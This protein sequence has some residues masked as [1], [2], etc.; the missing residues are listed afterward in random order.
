LNGKWLIPW[1]RVKEKQPNG[2][3]NVE[4]AKGVWEVIKKAREK[5]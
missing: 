5:Y 2:A 1:A 4:V 3:D